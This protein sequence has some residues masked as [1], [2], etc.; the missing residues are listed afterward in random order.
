META[1]GFSAGRLSGAC[2]P[3][4][5]RASREIFQGKE[6]M[7]V[8][9][10]GAGEV[11][12]YIAQKLSEE[13]QDVVLIDKDPEKIT[14]ITEALDVQAYLGSGTSPNILKEAGIR[15]ADLLVAATDS[16]EVNL[17]SC[18]LV[19]NLS[20]YM[21]KVARVRNQEYLDEKEL[22]GPDLLGIDR[23]INPESVM[24][25]TIRELME[26]P[27]ACDVIELGD[28][29]IRLI[30][31]T[32]REDSALAG[33]KLLSLQG[34]ESKFLIGAI[35]RRTQVIIP[36]GQDAIEAEDLVYVVVKNNELGDVLE[37]F[38][39]GEER[40]RRVIIVGAGQAGMEL[41]SLLDKTKIAVK[42]IEKDK[43]RCVELAQ[44]LGHIVVI[45]GDGTD[46]E[47]LQEENIKGVDFLVALTE[48][49]ES[50][51]LMSLL[52][53][54]LG[55]RKTIS[56]VSKLGY[57]P[58]VSEIGIDAV[59]SSRLSAVRAILRY[60]RRGKILS[61]APLKGEHA[62][63]L[64]AEALETSDIVNVP[65]SQAGFPKDALVGAIVRGEEIIVPRGESVIMPKDRLIIFALAR[66]IPRLEKLLTVKL[67]YF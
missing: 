64:E 4:V 59:V 40:P 32:I 18:L 22:L 19:R 23:L 30:G 42:L 63:V 46:K 47:L 34:L 39:L 35:V 43:D 50:N 56:R 13:G 16:D 1:S 45:N 21:V 5:H 26:V 52:A 60:I 38:G 17:I 62:E 8:V 15:E 65:L 9:I 12:F 3:G 7:K 58:L 48:D 2:L 44:E 61:A 36:H 27:G 51:V 53:K 14:R 49:E 41:A 33:R 55:A 66:V 10:V 28:G 20:P 25:E 24:V 57:I 31:F 29:R 54:G 6:T 67:E 37:I 11:G